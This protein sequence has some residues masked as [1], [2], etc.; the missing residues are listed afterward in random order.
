MKLTDTAVTDL[1][2]DP[3]L[4]GRDLFFALDPPPGL[5]EI[6]AL[7]AALGGRVLTLLPGPVYACGHTDV[8][9]LNTPQALAVPPQSDAVL[10]DIRMLGAP[11]AEAYI[12]RYAFRFFLLPFYETALLTEYGYRFSYRQIAELRAGLPYPVRILGVSAS[13]RLDDAVREALG[14]LKFA[15]LELPAKRRLCGV[16]TENETEKFRLAARQCEKSPYT[17][18]ILLCA[19]RT[20]AEHLH[21][22]FRSWGLQ[23]AL[24]HGGRGRSDNEAA[25]GQYIKGETNVLI[26]TKSLLPSYPFLKADKLFYCGLPYSLTHADRCAALAETGELICLWCADDIAV[27]RKQTAD[28]AKALQISDPTF[29]AKRNVD[30]NAL[31]EYLKHET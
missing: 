10:A 23:A 28:F 31:L 15:L 6:A 3:A 1:I 19:T 27:L 20:E 8:T 25:L 7:P 17:R 21:A 4:Q 13:D 11:E 14:A 16:E 9:V 24:F 29:T 2:K 22:F 12:T 5:P 18:H 30:L 26:G